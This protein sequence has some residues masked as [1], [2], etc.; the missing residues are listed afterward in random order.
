MEF[1]STRDNTLVSQ[2]FFPNFNIN[3]FV[4]FALP[5]LMTFL[6]SCGVTVKIQTLRALAFIA[7]CH[8]CM[9]EILNIFNILERLLYLNCSYCSYYYCSYCFFFIVCLIGVIK[10]LLTSRRVRGRC[11]CVKVDTNNFSSTI[12][13]KWLNG[14]RLWKPY[15]MRICVT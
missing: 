9:F 4:I 8:W 15:S 5:E 13:S 6:Q 1:A 2:L 11:V 7:Y 12:L 10:I 3:Y 14:F